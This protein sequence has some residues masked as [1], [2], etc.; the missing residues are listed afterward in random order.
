ME[1]L[2]VWLTEFTHAHA[3]HSV[4]TRITFP[5]LLYRPTYQHLH[6]LL[7]SILAVPVMALK[8]T[9]TPQTRD[10]LKS[11]LREPVCEIGSVNKS[12]ITYTV[13]LLKPAST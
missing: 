2:Q 13:A 1:V 8:A 7:S 5:Y 12:N 6:D 4:N 3:F 9:A 10:M 11:M